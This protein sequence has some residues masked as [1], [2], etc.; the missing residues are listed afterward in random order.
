MV[1]PVF[2]RLC[3]EKPRSRVRRAAPIADADPMAF[4]SSRFDVRPGARYLLAAAAGYALFVVY[5]SLLPLE[6]RPLPLEAAWR[7]FA[8]MPMRAL[9]AEKRADWVANAVLYVPL[10]VLWSASLSRRRGFALG[11]APGAAV[12]GGCIG[13]ALFVEFLQ[14]FF[15]PRT[16]SQND[17]LAEVLGSATG[18]ALW[19]ACGRRAARLVDDIH[20]SGYIA[21]RAALNAYTAAY[22][23]LAFFPY[24][25]VVSGA[26]FAARLEGGSVHALVAPACGGIL[27][28]G[29]KLGVEVAL[30]V[31][32]G[33]LLS[34][35]LGR[36]HR[37][38]VRA[39]LLVGVALGAALEAGQFLLH[40]GVV[41]GVS[42]LSRGLGVGL[43]VAAAR[44]LADMPAER[45]KPTVRTAALVLGPVY[46]AGLVAAAWALRPPKL[47]WTA[48]AAAVEQISWLP[49]HYHYFATE[50][51]ALFSLAMN[52]ALYAPLGL[53]LSAWRWAN[54]TARLG[55]AATGL[56]AASLAVVVEASR[57]FRADAGHPDPTNILIAA[58]AALL[59]R[60]AVDWTVR[61]FQSA[62]PSTAP[63][64]SP[65]PLPRAVLPPLAPSRLPPVGRRSSLV[66]QRA[67][68]VGLLLGIAV[69]LAHHPVAPLVLGAALALYVGLLVRYPLAW[70]AA[71]PALLPLADLSP[72]T[73]W[74]LLDEFD[75][76]VMATLAANLWRT[77]LERPDFTLPRAAGWAVLLLAASYAA[78]A[79][80][81]LLPLDALDWNAIG[82][83]DTRYN[84]LRLLKPCLWALALLPFF[85]SAHRRHPRA[86]LMLCSGLAAG[87][88]ALSLVVL[89]ERQL[90]AGL[91][92]FSMDYRVT[93]SFFSM[94]VGD[95][96]IDAFLVAAAPFV[97]AV[98]LWRPRSLSLAF[99]LLLSVACFYA[100]IVTYSRGTYLALAVAVIVAFVGHL[101]ARRGPKLRRGAAGAAAV[102]LGF[103]L[104][105][106]IAA[107]LPYAKERFA[108]SSADLHSRVAKWRNVLAARDRDVA[109]KVLGMGLGT[110]PRAFRARNASAAA[111]GR[112]R[113]ATEQGDAF[114]RFDL[115]KPIF[116]G[117]RVRLEPH[118]TYRF[119]FD[120]RA[121]A[122]RN[123]VSVYLCERSV[124]YSF[125]CVSQSMT[126]DAPPG[127]WYRYR[128]VLKTTGQ[129]RPLGHF[130]WLSERPL[131]VGLIYRRGAG[132]LDIDNFR[133]LDEAGRDRV[134]NGDFSRGGERWFFSVDHHHL[135]HEDSL[136]VHLLF[137]R[138]WFGLLAFAGLAAVALIALGRQ[139]WRGDRLAPLLFAAI[140]GFLAVGLFGTL[141]DT[142]R[143]SLLGLLLL[144]AA[145][146]G[147]APPRSATSPSIA[148]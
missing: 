52:A 121:A 38:P 22:V 120:A 80:R 74:L 133:L 135:W 9:G 93:G 14:V 36:S 12:L 72:W 136:F 11:I 91:L 128:H 40:S 108:S 21:L 147:P 69:L 122:G 71:L 141:V 79:L 44:L 70:L 4:V 134:A 106:G 25:F 55:I 117:Q 101:I 66:P 62:T 105:A 127:R 1:T 34:F 27:R 107:S 87:L 19:A 24:D 78:S 112:H 116:F 97:A 10:A 46:G 16:T 123:E 33:A 51:R 17:L 32:L 58:V 103:A 2:C 37:H 5:G 109:T 61:V 42:I 94:H 50:Q 35:V 88:G 8:D 99:A 132:P 96:Y 20:S 31:P 77:P 137:E 60:A 98:L 129:G 76:V 41:Q 45:I 54:G 115:G 92:N 53:V 145:I 56:L 64:A 143:I 75:L 3:A 110:F 81:G 57:L 86:R 148:P 29:A 130:G 142:P 28:C 100:V 26:E 68:A 95:Q 65:T 131:E 47:D 18:V 73:G 126:F 63:L 83:Y 140:V 119:E 90:F 124:L 43:G 49:F 6:F 111:A 7:A 144:F 138:G 104:M 85:V 84:A 23:L 67:V 125:D 39:G 139:T 13:L 89:Y 82:T 102:A 15:P 118:A 48:A 146:C 59:G 114:V 113:F 30:L